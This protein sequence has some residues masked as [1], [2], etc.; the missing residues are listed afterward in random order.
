MQKYFYSVG[1]WGPKLSI[2]PVFYPLSIVKSI[3]TNRATKTHHS[4]PIIHFP[5]I[6][7]STLHTMTYWQFDKAVKSS[8]HTLI[9]PLPTKLTKIAQNRGASELVWAGKWQIARNM[10]TLE[11]KIPQGHGNAK[12]TPC[13]ASLSLLSHTVSHQPAKQM[14]LIKKSHCASGKCHVGSKLQCTT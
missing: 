14:Q 2:L 9:K 10:V 8:L 3:K 12:D 13:T 1:P 4:C 11:T 6:Q 5:L 7:S